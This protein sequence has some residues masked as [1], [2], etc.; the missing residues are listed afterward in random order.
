LWP[1]KLSLK[2]TDFIVVKLEFYGAS[3]NLPSVK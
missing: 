1:Q 2:Y 3:V